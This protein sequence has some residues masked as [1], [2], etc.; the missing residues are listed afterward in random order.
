MDENFFNTHHPVFRVYKFLPCVQ[1]TMTRTCSNMNSTGRSI[2]FAVAVLIF[3]EVLCT[4]SYIFISDRFNDVY[5][6]LFL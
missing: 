3:L 5:P 4:Y 2:L 1:S 6:R